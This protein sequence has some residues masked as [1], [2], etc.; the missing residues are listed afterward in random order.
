MARIIRIHNRNVVPTNP[1]NP[2]PPVNPANPAPPA[3]QGNTANTAPAVQ[4]Q[5][6]NS[7]TPKMT[8]KEWMRLIWAIGSSMVTFWLSFG[9]LCWFA[10]TW[11]FWIKVS[12]SF[13]MA[14]IT[15]AALDAATQTKS[16][17]GKSI[18]LF[19]IL[20]AAFLLIFHYGNPSKSEPETKKTEV[21][22]TKPAV[23]APRY[24][25]YNENGE[26]ILSLNQGET[27]GWIKVGDC[28]R[29]N[30]SHDNI[31]L[32]YEDG[33]KVNVSKLQNLPN[34]SVF[35]VTNLDETQVRLLVKPRY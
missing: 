27:S 6:P 5:T 24:M 4:P 33:S 23:S 13:I 10:P 7:P 20:Q 8:K 26:F 30:F 9:L 2:V 11:Y 22:E 15:L 1:V 17:L 31:I 35:K 25:E 34:Q 28:H 32:E 19:I 29:Y 12:L 18:I 14:A 16:G 21:V 3:N